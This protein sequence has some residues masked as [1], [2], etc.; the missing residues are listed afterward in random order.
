MTNRQIT[1][2]E[3]QESIDNYQEIVN[4]GDALERLTD[5]E[6]FKKVFTEGYFK[7]EAAR[8]VSICADLRIPADQ[9]EDTK[10]LMTGISCVQSYMQVVFQ[11]RQSALTQIDAGLEELKDMRAEEEASAQLEA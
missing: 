4:L 8:L 7:E 3:I 6:D 5:N 11:K 9:R 2:E 1:Q 10:L